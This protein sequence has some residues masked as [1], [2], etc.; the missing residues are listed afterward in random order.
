MKTHPKAKLEPSVTLSRLI[1]RNKWHNEHEDTSPLASGVDKEWTRQN[2]L[3]LLFLSRPHLVSP[4]SLLCHETSSRGVSN[5][6]V[7]LMHLHFIT[8]YLSPYWFMLL[9][10]TFFLA[11]STLSTAC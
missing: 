4:F 1:A 8:W 10:E 11:I 6:F 9:K 7:Q 3:H 2:F 5:R